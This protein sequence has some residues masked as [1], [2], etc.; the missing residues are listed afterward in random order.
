M[1]PVTMLQPVNK[2]YEFNGAPTLVDGLKGNGNYKTGRWI[3][4]YKNDMEAVIDLKEPTEFKVL[5]FYLCEKGEL[6]I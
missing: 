5:Y 1:K 3:A 6:G 4:F 2:Q